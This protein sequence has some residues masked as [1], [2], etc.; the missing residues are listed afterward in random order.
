MVQG[1]CHSQPNATCC[2]PAARCWKCIVQVVPWTYLS[3]ISSYLFTQSFPRNISLQPTKSFIALC[4]PWLHCALQGCWDCWRREK[5]HKRGGISRCCV[6]HFD[7]R[8]SAALRLSSFT[9]RRYRT[10]LSS[11]AHKPTRVHGRDGLWHQVFKPTLFDGFEQ[12]YFGQDVQL[13]VTPSEQVPNRYFCQSRPCIC[14]ADAT[15]LMRYTR[16]STTL[17][18]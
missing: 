13:A 17:L 15:R 1:S 3:C 10:G 2:K 4:N 8:N 12:A 6:S 7:F 16:V 9:F 14:A 5:P 11:A 18:I